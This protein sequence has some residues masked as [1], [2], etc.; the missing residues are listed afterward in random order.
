MKDPRY[1]QILA[2]TGLLIYGLGWLDFPGPGWIY[3]TYPAAAL[4][5]QWG[6]SRWAGILFDPRSPLIS[7]LSL[8]LLLHTGSLLWAIVA[9]AIT[10]GGKFLLRVDGRHV[11]NPTNLAIVTLL[12][13]TDQVWVSPGQWGLGTFL[14]FAAVCMGIWVLYHTRRSDVTLA[15][16]LAWT[17]LVYGRALWLG[18]PL[19]IPLLQLQNIG[20]LVFAFF[21]ISDPM[22]MPDR[23]SARIGF[24]FLVAV[25]GY[26]LQYQFYVNEGLFYALAAC[27]PLVPLF[28]RLLPGE[29]YLWPR[30][31]FILWR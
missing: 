13:L 11:F 16:L 3:P 4:I 30:S 21:M 28:N 27:A 12:L 19:S 26:V 2:L 1:L 29:R 9:A 8:C 20:L 15:F 24:A 5:F 18:D 31:P 14:G 10:V 17:A 23:R 22:T 7:S 6:F 25:V